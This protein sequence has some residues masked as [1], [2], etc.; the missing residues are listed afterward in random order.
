MA[1]M[2][3]K[4]VLKMPKPSKH[5]IVCKKCGAIMLE[6]GKKTHICKRKCR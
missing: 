3:E 2:K 4:F 5:F 1:N 6:Q